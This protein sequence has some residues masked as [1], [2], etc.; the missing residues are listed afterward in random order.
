MH[1]S[2]KCCQ[3]G[4]K[5]QMGNQVVDNEAGLESVSMKDQ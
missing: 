3:P 1:Y 4:I 5:Y 2:N